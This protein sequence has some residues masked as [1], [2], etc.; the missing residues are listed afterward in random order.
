MYYRSGRLGRNSVSSSGLFL[1]EE[2]EVR[3]ALLAT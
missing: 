3:G 1:F 2:I